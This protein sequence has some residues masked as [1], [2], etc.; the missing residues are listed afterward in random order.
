MIIS[1]DRGVIKMFYATFDS[2]EKIDDPQNGWGEI[3]I[4]SI[5]LYRFETQKKRDQFVDDNELAQTISAK[6]AKEQ[7]KEQFQ[8]WESL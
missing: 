2:R 7:H 3:E 4:G 5:D 1:I 6:D 8:Y